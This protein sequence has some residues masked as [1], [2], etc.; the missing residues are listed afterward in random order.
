MHSV[1]TGRRFNRH[2]LADDRKPV[3]LADVRGRAGIGAALR[4]NTARDLLR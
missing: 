1:S 2:R 4:E 3:S